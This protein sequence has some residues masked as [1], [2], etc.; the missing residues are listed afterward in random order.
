M[1]FSNSHQTYEPSGFAQF[2]LLSQRT[3]SLR[4]SAVHRSERL[5][6]HAAM[7]RSQPGRLKGTQ[8]AS[9]CQC[10]PFVPGGEGRQREN[11]HCTRNRDFAERLV[12]VASDQ[13]TVTCVEKRGMSRR[14]ARRGNDFERANVIAFV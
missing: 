6:K 1:P 12:R 4:D 7:A 2:L 9:A 8:L 10:Q 5:F 3:C 14:V 13:G 11:G